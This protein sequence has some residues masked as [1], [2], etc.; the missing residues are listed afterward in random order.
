MKFVSRDKR[1]AGSVRRLTLCLAAAALVPLLLYGSAPS[2]WLPRG[3]LAEGQAADDY[4]PVNQGQLKNIAKSAAAEMDAKLN[5]GAG[6]ELQTL[7]Q[8]LGQPII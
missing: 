5:G 2:W 1:S 3:V 6:L 4:A 7:I 8:S